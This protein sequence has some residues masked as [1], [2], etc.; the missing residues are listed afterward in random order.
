MINNTLYTRNK[1]IIATDK[2]D[3]Q[4]IVEL[5]KEEAIKLGLLKKD[6]IIVQTSNGIIIDT[7]VDSDEVSRTSYKISNLSEQDLSN[8]DKVYDL[9]DPQDFETLRQKT[10]MSYFNLDKNP[11]QVFWNGMGNTKKSAIT[12]KNLIEKDFGKTGLFFNKT[13]GLVKDVLE[14]LPNNLTT[15]DILNANQ[16]RKLPDS[17]TVITHS[18]GNEDIYKAGKVADLEG[19]K[20]KHIKQISVGSPSSKTDLINQGSKVGIG[21]VVQISHP[22]DPITVFN[23]DADYEVDYNPLSNNVKSLK[24]KFIPVIEDQQENHGFDKYYPKVK[25]ELNKIRANKK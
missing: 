12:S 21:S 11:K 5:T 19:V 4:K 20:F 13:G 10:D 16:L 22:N 1:E 17:T 14:Y 3:N 8:F 2:K 23:K 9:N 24:T 7:G 25:N 15:K 18:A 6:T